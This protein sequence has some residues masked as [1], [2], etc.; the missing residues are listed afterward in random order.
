MLSRLL[1]EKFEIIACAEAKQTKP[2]RE[3]FGN[4]YSAPADGASTAK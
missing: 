2:I 1:D 4:F 3:I